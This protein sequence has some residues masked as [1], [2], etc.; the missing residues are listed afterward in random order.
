MTPARWRNCRACRA[1]KTNWPMASAKLK[2]TIREHQ[3]STLRA[4][5]GSIKQQAATIYAQEFTR[6]ELI[7][8]RELSKDPVMRK[9]RARMKIMAPKLMALGVYTM[10]AAEPELKV[11]I[12]RLVTDYLASKGTDDR[13]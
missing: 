3:E 1:P 10:R 2:A 7:R 6:D 8:L 5:M 13:S 4:N 11:K 12:D 9:A